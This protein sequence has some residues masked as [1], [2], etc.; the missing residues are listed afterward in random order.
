M[1][2]IYGKLQVGKVYKAGFAEATTQA[3]VKARTKSRTIQLSALKLKEEKNI[4]SSQQVLE[5][6][7]VKKNNFQERSYL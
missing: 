6:K 2:I 4:V 7:I 1:F 5:V 3:P